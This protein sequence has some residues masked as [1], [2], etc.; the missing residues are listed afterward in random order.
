ML[1]LFVVCSC[2]KLL[3]VCLYL[4]VPL[5]QFTF[6]YSV[7]FTGHGGQGKLLCFHQFFLFRN[8]V[9]QLFALALVFGTLVLKLFAQFVLILC[10]CLSGASFYLREQSITLLFQ[11][12]SLL[13][14]LGAVL[15]QRS[16][17]GVVLCLLRRYHLFGARLGVDRSLL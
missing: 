9:R 16:N 17:C 15:P 12:K 3:C 5:L 4:F 8:C 10:A 13:C 1:S 6:E 7:V 11:Q 2:G 14:E